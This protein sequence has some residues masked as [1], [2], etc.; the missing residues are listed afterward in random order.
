M[1][2]DVA[3]GEFLTAADVALD[4][5]APAVRIRREMERQA[6]PTAQV[7]AAE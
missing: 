4:G 1:L 3:A 5:N 6:Q 2:R 7:A